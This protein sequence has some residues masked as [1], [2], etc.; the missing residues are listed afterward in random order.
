MNHYEILGVPR[1]ATTEQLKKAYRTLSKQWH[2][3]RNPQ[4]KE[5]AETK[6]KEISEAY[7]ILSDVN[8]RRN[9]DCWGSKNAVPDYTD[10]TFNARSAR[11]IFEVFGDEDPG[12][13]GSQPFANGFT[14][15]M[16]GRRKQPPPITKQLF[17]TLEELY[18]GC[19]KKMR[20]IRQKF[21]Q[22]LQISKPEEKILRI[23][24]KPGWKPGTRIT[25]EKTGDEGPGMIAADI[26]FV[27]AETP[28]K[29]FRRHRN[30]LYMKKQIHLVDALIG[31]TIGVPLLDGNTLEIALTDRVIHP[32]YTHTS[33]GHG[34][35]I[36]KRP[37]E[38]GDLVIEF[39]VVFPKTLTPEQ[40]RMAKQCIP[41]GSVT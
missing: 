20:V 17:C 8:K 13:F 40:K 18:S 19:V 29:I 34:M 9:Y 37:G 32:G 30:N 41:R 6:F 35:P 28:H 22:Q 24:V 27:L 10:F 4:N 21:D 2:P 14:G 36:S 31:T 39:V 16:N 12:F 11:D 33:L 23:D 3:D 7:C 25:F 5:Q 1:D 38:A 26:V 15:P